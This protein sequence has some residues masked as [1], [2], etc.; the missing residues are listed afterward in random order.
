VTRTAI[1]LVCQAMRRAVPILAVVALAGCTGHARYVGVP[2]NHGRSLDD[3]L[4]RLHEAGLRATFPAARTSCGDALPCVNVQSPRAPARARQ[5]S[6]VTM[7]FGVT[8]IPSPGSPLHHPPWVFV[9]NLVAK[10]W[11]AA[12]KVLPQSIWPCVHVAGARGTTAARLVV[13]S[14]KPASGVRLPAYGV[15]S[16]GGYRP[17]T[18]NVFLEAR[19]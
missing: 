11:A 6:T 3:A 8:P 4:R 10:E 15:L 5:G 18:V 13:V 12:A 2:S 1:L 9:P 17:T 7:R 16:G 19:P 14:Q